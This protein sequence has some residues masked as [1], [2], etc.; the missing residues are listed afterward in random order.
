MMQDIQ[1]PPSSGCEL[2]HWHIF[3]A[4]RGEKQ[5]PSSGCELKPTRRRRGTCRPGQPPSSGCELKPY[6]I[7]KGFD[8][9]G[10]AAFERL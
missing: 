8:S 7:Y 1:Q 2:K 5:P 9:Y 10:A 6:V 4:R 3:I